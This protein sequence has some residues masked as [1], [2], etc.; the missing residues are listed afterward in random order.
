MSEAVQE[1]K[2]QKI[3]SP[4]ELHDYIHVTG[5]GLWIVL[6]MIIVFLAALIVFSSTIIMENTMDV[7]VKAET[8]RTTGKTELTC[9]L[10]DSRKDLVKVGM[11]VRVAGEEGS[12]SELFEQDGEEM[13][14]ISMNREDA[15]LRE[16]VY[17]AE[18][19]LEAVSPVSFLLN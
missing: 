6:T 4:E 7:Q 5:P 11:K 8:V 10:A 13:V 9:V 3:T 2:R 12:I 16:G 14:L 18:I 17:D 1:Q 19:V 15:R